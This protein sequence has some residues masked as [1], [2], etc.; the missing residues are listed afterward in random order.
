MYV[1]VYVCI[2]MYMSYLKS[3]VINHLMAYS[4]RSVVDSQYLQVIKSY[5]FQPKI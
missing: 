4:D 2:Y 1:C 5:I 3:E